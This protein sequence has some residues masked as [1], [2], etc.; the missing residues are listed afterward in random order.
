MPGDAVARV[1]GEVIRR[2]EYQRVLDALAQDKR[3]PLDDA[4]R[5]RVLD[6]L[7]DEELLVQRGVELGL[8]RHDG[9]IRKDLTNAVIDSVIAEFNDVA[10]ADQELQSFYD[11]QRELF[12]GPGRLHVRQIFCR[13]PT[14]ADAPMAFER[15]QQAAQRLRAG[16]DF[17]VVR[18]ALGDQE[19][20]PL[21]DSLLPQPKLIDYLGPTAAQTATTLAVGEVSDPVRSSTGYHVLQLIEQ[22][23]NTPPPLDEIKPQVLA[24]Y[25]RRASERALRAYLDDL[26]RRA[27]VDFGESIP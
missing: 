16:E 1:N 3:T 21:P 5:R 2:D 26:R 22:Q 19:L 18:V 8:A 9:K 23:P 11:D 4:E 25:R 13:A 12:A 14:N 24:E 15:A 17:E 6:R 7:I 27:Q 20:A 10:P